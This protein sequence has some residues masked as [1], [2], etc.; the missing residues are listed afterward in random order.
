MRA[1][2]LPATSR[3]WLAQVAAHWAPATAAALPPD[4]ARLY[5]LIFG[6]AAL[7]NLGFGLWAGFW[8][9]H[10]FDLT[11]L[12][13]PL[14]PALWRCLGMV[15]GVYALGYAYAARRLDRAHPFIAIGLLGK[16][17]G[18]LGWLATVATGEWPLRTFTL[19]VFNDLIWWLPFA[20]FLLEG[21]ALGR[22]ARGLAPFACAA[23]NAL[24]SVVLLATLRPGTE[25]EPS[26]AARAAYIA[27]YPALWRGGWLVWMAAAI[28]LL[29]FYAWWGA[30]TPRHGAALAAFALGSAGLVCDLF[31]ESLYIG[32][33][34][35]HLPE[36]QRPAALLTSGLANGLYT[37]AGITL[38]QASPWLRGPARWWAW[39]AWL[40]GLA[41]SAAAVAGSPAF[42]AVAAAGLMLLFCPFAAWLGWHLRGRAAC[43]A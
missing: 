5:R 33:F 6:V 1:D 16:V 35:Q 24:A 12:A 29:G 9:E 17:L 14:Y 37:L 31:A 15:V 19:I 39:G 11:R 3:S 43:G 32:W 7:Y 23:L 30:R 21:S 4:R 36:L 34:P 42:M 40:S 2:V 18:P 20:L 38:T 22:R 26:L 10:F 13:P 28:S 25:A 41:L 27:A 8:P